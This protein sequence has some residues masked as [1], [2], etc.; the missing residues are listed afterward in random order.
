[1]FALCACVYSNAL[2]VPLSVPR[3]LCL[4]CPQLLLSANTRDT[5]CFGY[6]TFNFQKGRCAFM[7]GSGQTWKVSM[8]T[9]VQLCVLANMDKRTTCYG[10][11][12][13]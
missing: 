10:H 9:F 2:I 13:V 5:H 8:S 3:A 12:V 6:G 1:M 7:V 4:C 11:I